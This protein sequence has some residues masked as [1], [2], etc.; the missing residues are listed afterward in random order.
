MTEKERSRSQD[1]NQCLK[2]DEEHISRS[3][4]GPAAL[5][6]AAAVES[7]EGRKV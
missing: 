3:R 5:A 2:P 6:A 1:G 4:E 7:E